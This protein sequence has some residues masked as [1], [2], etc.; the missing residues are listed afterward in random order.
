MIRNAGKALFTNLQG[1]ATVAS[2][3]QSS[4]ERGRLR[5]YG[6]VIGCFLD[7]CMSTSPGRS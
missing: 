1:A 3:E 4:K 6:A 5:G 2:Q 7:D